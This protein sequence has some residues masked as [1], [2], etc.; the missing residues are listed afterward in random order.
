[1]KNSMNYS[2]LSVANVCLIAAIAVQFAG[3]GGENAEP[4]VTT[5]VAEDVQTALPE[6]SD[7]D[8]PTY[9]HDA[10]GWRYNGAETQLSPQNAAQLELKWRFPPRGSDQKIGVVHA[11]PSVV[12]SHVYFGTATAPA[13]YKL[14]PDGSLAWVY[15]LDSGATRGETPPAGGPNLIDADSGIMASALVTQDSVYFG[16]SAGVFYALDRISGKEKWKVDTRAEGFP[17]H[18]PINIFNASA[19][20]ADGKVIVGGG[21]YEHPYPLDPDYECCTGRGFV[22]AFDPSDGDVIWKYE[23]GEK[24]QPF[25]DPISIEDDYGKHT[26]KYGPSTS[27][28]W[29]TPTY[30][31]ATDTI[32]FGTD[33]NNSPR[34]PTPDNPR[35]DSEYSAAVVAVDVKTGEEKW[36]RQLHEGDIFNHSMAGYD[37]NTRRYKDCSVG[38]SPKVYAIEDGSSRRA[39]VGV[40]CKN[41]CFYMLDA[42]DG[43]IVA[44]TPMYEGRPQYPLKPKPDPRMIALPSVIGGI[45]TGCGFDGENV[46]TNGIDWVTLNTRTP[47]APEG[48]R[49]VCLSRDL[50][51]EHWRHERPRISVPQYTGGDPVASG[52]ALAG[53]VA[54]FTTTVSERLV[55]LDASSGKT[56]KEIPVGTVWSGPSISRGRIYVGTGSILFLKKELEGSVQCYGLPNEKVEPVPEP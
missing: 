38:D 53:G 8:W 25:P 49:V 14:R 46:F 51:S 35:L 50:S 18:H 17:G 31:A 42:S 16:D 12:N 37:S 5:F 22:V 54:A 7:S 48:G 55:I 9:N 32:Y 6:I 3:C 23:V 47:L 19:I 15:Q 1:M 33:V 34:Q 13:F 4:L 26:Y 43:T 39:V 28:V 11:T 10:E 27:S 40:G 41:G 36:V 29:S 56:I 52:V 45:Q 24:P 30:D 2:I 21:G 20:L 44:R